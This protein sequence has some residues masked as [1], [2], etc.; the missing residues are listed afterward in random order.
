MRKTKIVATIGP[1]SDDA[2][3]LE[4]LV[5]AGMNVARQNFSHGTHAE[6]EEL[7]QTVRNISDDVATM[8]DTQGPEVRLQ[9]VEKE[10]MLTAGNTVTITTGGVTE[11]PQ[12]AV[13]Y[14]TLLDAAEPGDTVII[15]DGDIELEVTETAADEI[16]C[17]VVYG[18]SITAEKGVNIPGKDVSPDGLTQQD[19]EDI[20]FGARNH[21]DFI[22]VSFVKNADDIYDARDIAEEYGSGTQLIAKIEHID[23]VD[24]FDE[25]LAAADGIMIARG[26]LGVEL[27]ESEVPVLQKEFIAACNRAGKPVITATQMLTSMTE[28][29]HATRAE[30]S[31]VANAVNDGTDAVMLSEETATGNYPVEAVEAMDTTVTRME[32]YI[33]DQVPETVKEPRE[34]I[35]AVIAKSI[36]QAARDLDPRYIVAHTSSGYTARQIAKYRPDTDIIAFTNSAMVKRQLQLVWGVTAFTDSFATYVEEM[37][38]DSTEFLW[39]EGMVEE[40]DLL[41]MSAGIPT[42]TSGTTNMMKIRTVSDILDA[43]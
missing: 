31:D 42:S 28:Q 11:A 25:I 9:Q 12:L 15:G 13:N 4:A 17:E 7:L 19:R 32:E 35:S 37:I 41:V 5:D 43:V 3:T 1:A 39:D 27:P 23:A 10:S 18:G 33:A 16:T 26:D 38:E 21:F 40:N 8:L 30:I 36:W 22:S 29:P 6:H 20:A 24:N 34:N 2:E 14:D